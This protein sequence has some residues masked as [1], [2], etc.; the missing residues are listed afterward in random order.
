[1]A[2]IELLG[3]YSFVASTG[4]MGISPYLNPDQ[5]DVPRVNCNII[6][7]NRGFLT[8][9]QEAMLMQ[10]NHKPSDR[11]TVNLMNLR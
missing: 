8:S 9:V 5:T 3:K 11:L 2:C 1:M 6:L 10:V 7:P 4:S